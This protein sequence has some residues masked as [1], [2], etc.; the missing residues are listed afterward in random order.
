MMTMPQINPRWRLQ[1]EGQTEDIGL[2]EELVS[3][4]IQNADDYM[5]VRMSGVV[6]LQALE[7]VPQGVE[8]SP[9]R[10]STPSFNVPVLTTIKWD[11]L[12]THD[13]VVSK[14]L[15]VLKVLS[16]CLTLLTVSA[17]ITIGTVYEICPDGRI[18][19]TRDTTLAY[20]VRPP[21]EEYP[22]AFQFRRVVDLTDKVDVLGDLL[23][24]YA[25]EPDWFV[26]Y[27]MIEAIE[28]HIGGERKMMACPYLEGAELKR[29]KQMANS[30]RH[31]DSSTHRPP[32]ELM[33][34]SE[35][36]ALLRR[37]V[38]ALI[39]EISKRVA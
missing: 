16:G 1:L 4:S 10:E 6:V 29:A 7:V 34:L 23:A 12:A 8:P 27:K 38:T 35:A 13:E 24:M 39:G 32:T 5:I 22:S 18:Q 30:A 37:S 36:Q 11:T 19:A 28:K 17:P 9:P 15:P 33:A 14:A 31:L 20:R 25:Q 21:K 3:K 2:L 26:V